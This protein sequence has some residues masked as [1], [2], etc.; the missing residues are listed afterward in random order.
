MG[1]A[2]G[3]D[4]GVHPRGGEEDNVD[5]SKDDKDNSVEIEAAFHLNVEEEKE[6][7]KDKE[8]PVK[9]EVSEHKENDEDEKKPNKVATANG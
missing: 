1:R 5:S 3:G 4:P 6:N 9:Q 7:E 8:K 2:R